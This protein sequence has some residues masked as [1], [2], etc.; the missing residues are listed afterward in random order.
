MDFW[1]ERGEAEQLAAYILTLRRA[2]YEPPI[3]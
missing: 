1:I 2:G 3:Q